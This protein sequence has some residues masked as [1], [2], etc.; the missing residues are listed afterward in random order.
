MIGN[1]W[2]AHLDLEQL[3]KMLDW[4]RVK[5]ADGRRI[6]PEEENLLRAFVLTPFEDVKVVILGQD[7]YPGAD[8]DGNWHAMGM[9]FSSR[10]KIEVPASLKNIFKELA[11]ET[12]LDNKTA[13]LTKWA[14][15]G[16]LLLNTVLTGE[17]GKAN[18]HKN[19]GWETI[20]T[21]AIQ[22][23]G[24]SAKPM[25]FMLWGKPAQKNVPF[26]SHNS[27]KLVLQAAHPSPLSAH[28]GFFGCNHFVLANEFLVAKGAGT[29]DWSLEEG[30]P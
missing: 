5:R 29:I 8:K 21:G 26:I 24:R 4:T 7:P 17:A 6:L 27:N 9:A 12:G 19:M 28:K 22:S 3:R 14:Q 13:D 2:D 16:V 10:S 11:A 20:T 1:S 25:V 23:L 30:G 15:Q 18:A